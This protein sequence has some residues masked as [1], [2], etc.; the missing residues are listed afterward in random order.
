MFV[1]PFEL[2]HMYLVVKNSATKYYEIMPYIFF[3]YAI[4][5]SDP[6]QRQV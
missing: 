5:L 6:L 4:S 2:K 3:P 1:A